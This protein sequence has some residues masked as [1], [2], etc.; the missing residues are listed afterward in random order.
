MIGGLSVLQISTW[1]IPILVAITLHE[2]A[3]AYVAWKLGDDTAHQLGRVTFNPFRHIDPFGTILLP[4]LLIF[5]R[6][7]FL[8]GY[9]KPVPV[10]YYRLRRP[11]RDMVLVAA[12]GPAMNIVLALA[13]GLLLQLEAF[14]PAGAAA[15]YTETMQRGIV[16][17]LLLAV[18]NM[19]PLPPLD[20]GRVA[21]GLLPRS[22]ARPLA[23]LE[24][25]GFFI[26]IGFMLFLPSI[27]LQLLGREISVFAS[28][29]LP[30]VRFLG[31]LVLTVTGHG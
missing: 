22:L 25:F 3:H 17:N 29:I 1:V 9:A 30:V 24:R 8:I 4:A 16:L 12:A 26:L 6:A 27:S 10:N 23:R 5:V 21:V 11:R 28:I 2:A 15:W 7:P 20:G 31:R 14:L 13:A 18:F 19:I